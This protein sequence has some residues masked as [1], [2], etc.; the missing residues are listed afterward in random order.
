MKIQEFMVGVTIA[1]GMQGCEQPA[2]L[3]PSSLAT[4]TDT[5]LR[6]FVA[7]VKDNLIFVEGGEFLMGDFGLQYAPERAPYDRDQD[8]KPL[9]RIELSSYSISRFK[10]T[11]AEFQLYINY[12]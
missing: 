3:T 9:H 8:S 12:N 11:N 6:K 2:P 10:V 4:V 7:S 5:E 1:L